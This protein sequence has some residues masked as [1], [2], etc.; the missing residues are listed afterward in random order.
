MVFLTQAKNTLVS[1]HRNSKKK[2]YLTGLRILSSVPVLQGQA[3][4]VYV[5]RAYLPLLCFFK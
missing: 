4:A 2:L 1:F 5:T 3:S